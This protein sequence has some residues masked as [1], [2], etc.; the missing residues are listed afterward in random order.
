MTA[1]TKPGLVYFRQDMMHF[2][3][4]NYL[5]AF[6][7]APDKL[8]WVRKVSMT[9]RP[10]GMVRVSVGITR[11]HYERLLARHGDRAGVT[12]AIQIAI[13]RVETWVRDVLE[14][15]MELAT[16]PFSPPPAPG[17]PRTY[18]VIWTVNHTLI[19]FDAIT[20]GVGPLPKVRIALIDKRRSRTLKLAVT[21][22]EE[23]DEIVA[24]VRTRSIGVA[25]WH[26]IYHAD[27]QAMLASRE[28]GESA[29][30]GTSG[31]AS[32]SVP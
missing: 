21:L 27:R 2:I 19:A 25:V 17:T 10:N 5:K 16:V 3:A 32:D 4:A 29:H 6:K 20:G 18:I 13:S 28:A 1:R 15:D 11:D 8:R 31:A 30:A 22:P 24:R 26:A 14:P 23:I 7:L 12:T 9:A